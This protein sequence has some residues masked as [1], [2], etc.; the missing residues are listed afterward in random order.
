MSLL[1]NFFNT[2]KFVSN[3]LISSL[4]AYFNVIRTQDYFLSGS[5]I[6]SHMHCGVKINKPIIHELMFGNINTFCVCVLVTGKK[7]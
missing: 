2:Y 1:K 6:L 3:I 7:F 5:E 4:G